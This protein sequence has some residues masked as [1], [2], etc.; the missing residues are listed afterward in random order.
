MRGALWAWLSAAA[1]LGGPLDLRP[2]E[3]DIREY[4]ELP[5]RTQAVGCG[6]VSRPIRYALR[7]FSLSDTF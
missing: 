7:D 2:G 6:Y 4:A 1:A 5:A 3:P